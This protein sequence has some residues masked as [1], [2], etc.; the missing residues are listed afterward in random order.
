M[1]CGRVYCDVWWCNLSLRFISYVVTCFCC[2]YFMLVSIMVDFI[3]VIL[4]FIHIIA[5]VWTY[6]EL[7]HVVMLCVSY[8]VCYVNFTCI[9][10]V[11]VVLFSFNIC[12]RIVG[13]FM[14]L[15]TCLLSNWYNFFSYRYFDVE[16]KVYVKPFYIV[17]SVPL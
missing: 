6:V 3:V 4:L 13:N 2:V 12:A 8:L 10:C 11:V 17:S 7:E 14:C 15:G 1:N 9:L 5:C 16:S